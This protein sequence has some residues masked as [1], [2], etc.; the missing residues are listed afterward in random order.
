MTDNVPTT[1]ENG[2]LMF[3]QTEHGLMQVDVHFEKS[4]K[5]M[6]QIESAAKKNKKGSK[7]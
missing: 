6:E 3:Y 1:H 2:D 4:L 5:K 7:K